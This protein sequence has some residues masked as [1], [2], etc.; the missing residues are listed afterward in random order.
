METTA[1]E[2]FPDTRPAIG[3]CMESAMRL[4]CPYNSLSFTDITQFSR[5][6]AS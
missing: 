3:A 6:T 2:P 1:F 5:L 4:D